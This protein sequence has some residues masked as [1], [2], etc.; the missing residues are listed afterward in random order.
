MPLAAARADDFFGLGSPG[1]SGA[2]PSPIMGMG[3]AGMGGMGGMGGR[4]VSGAMQSP[5]AAGMGGG[6]ATGAARGPIGGGPAP[7]AAAGQQAQ[8]GKKT[9]NLLTD[10]LFSSF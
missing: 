5:M 4:P 7:A 6:M 8:G 3:T 1:P 2:A 9:G 10:D